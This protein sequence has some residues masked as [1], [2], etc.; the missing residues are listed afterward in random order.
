MSA[1]DETR[2]VTDGEPMPVGI[3]DNADLRMEGGERVRRDF[4]PGLGN[5]GEQSGF[6]G[7]R[8]AHQADVRNEPKFEQK[9]AFLARFAR[10]RKTR[11]LS[12]G[13]GE[14]TIAQTATAA[15]A[16]DDLLSVRRQVGNQPAF[17]A[18]VRGGARGRLFFQIDFHRPVPACIT[19]PGTRT[20]SK[21]HRRGVR[22]FRLS[23][24]SRR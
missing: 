21:F 12:S 13:G 7:V 4:R 3:L 17:L 14:I 23:R 24:G 6:A 19:Q 20:R 16:E 18:R 22:C 8:V 5:G 2:H 10:L 15:F 1:L 9:I 11:R